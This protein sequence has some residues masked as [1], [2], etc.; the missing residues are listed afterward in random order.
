[1]DDLI[2]IPARFRPR[3]R[4][5]KRETLHAVQRRAGTGHSMF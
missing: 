4:R 5:V 3:C 2:T 1:V